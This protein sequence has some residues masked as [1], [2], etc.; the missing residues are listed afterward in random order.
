[1][2]QEIEKDVR[3]IVGH[4]NAM[5]SDSAAGQLSEKL[6]M[7]MDRIIASSKEKLTAASGKLSTGNILRFFKIV[8]I[9]PFNFIGSLYGHTKIIIN[10]QLR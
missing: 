8:I 1:M 9:Q 3:E 10:H 7:Y 6:S 5:D 4:T 2:K